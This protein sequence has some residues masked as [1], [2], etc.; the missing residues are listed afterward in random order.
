MPVPNLASRV[1]C[2]QFYWQFQNFMRARAERAKAARTRT[3]KA[4]W[5]LSF[6]RTVFVCAVIL[7]MC[8]SSDSHTGSGQSDNPG[9]HRQKNDTTSPI[10]HSVAALHSSMQMLAIATRPLKTAHAAQ[11]KQSRYVTVQQSRRRLTGI[12]AACV[13]V[14]LVGY[15]L[16]CGDVESNPGPGTGQ[17]AGYNGRAQ[18]KEAKRGVNTHPAQPSRFSQQPL[19]SFHAEIS[20][21]LNQAVARMESTTRQ[22]GHSIERRL[23]SVEEKID[24]RLR[25]VEVNQAQLS[26]SVDGLRSQCQALWSENQD[27]KTPSTISP[28]SATT[29]TIRADVTIFFSLALNRYGE[30][31]NPGRT[32]KEK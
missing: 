5:P 23:Q 26:S 25:E 1:V 21:I 7:L 8:S 17:E 22:Q 13:S 12:V 16:T 2:G 32:V 20:Y 31:R 18:G 3:V 28:T 14:L 24:H 19:D 6:V 10:Q 11:G 30:V 9:V 4:C 27:L 15:L 29:T